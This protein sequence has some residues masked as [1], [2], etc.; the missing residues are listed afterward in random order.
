MHKLSRMYSSLLQ[1][2]A[3]FYFVSPSCSLHAF[4]I[5]SKKTCF[6]NFN[7]TKRVFKLLIM[8][9]AD[10]IIFNGAACA[11]YAFVCE[12]DLRK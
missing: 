8:L 5:H 9:L 4:L 10:G 3:N 7:E 1:E 6:S 12:K 2:Q 11:E